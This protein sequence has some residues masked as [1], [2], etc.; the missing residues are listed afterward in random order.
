[1]LHR[2]LERDFRQPECHAIADDMV[3]GNAQPF[4]RFRHE[5]SESPIGQ[6]IPNSTDAPG[7]GQQLEIAQRDDAID[8]RS[9]HVPGG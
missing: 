9:R 2:P 7:V 6:S 3:F 4:T 8:L 1:M 5:L